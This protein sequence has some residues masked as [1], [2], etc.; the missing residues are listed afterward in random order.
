VS[1]FP[2]YTQDKETAHWHGLPALFWLNSYIA[3]Y[4]LAVTPQYGAKDQFHC[5]VYFITF[6]SNCEAQRVSKNLKKK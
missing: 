3:S 1:I 4:R 5:A 2:P 6:H